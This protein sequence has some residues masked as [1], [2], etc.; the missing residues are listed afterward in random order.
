M[1]NPEL[2]SDLNLEIEKSTPEIKSFLSG[3]Y[4]RDTMDLVIKVNKLSDDQAESVE[5]ETVL[6]ILDLSDHDNISDALHSECDISSEPVMSQVLKDLQEYIF[7][8]IDHKE[9]SIDSVIA[10]DAGEQSQSQSQSQS[11]SKDEDVDVKESRPLRNI[12][13]DVYGKDML[14]PVA[15][16]FYEDKR[17]AV[18]ESQISQDKNISTVQ[19]DTK[20]MKNVSNLGDVMH[21]VYREL[22]AAEDVD[23]TKI[24]QAVN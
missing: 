4:F 5:L 12:I 2:Q 1:L 16:D 21:D 6:N 24:T 15:L 22:P 13:Q 3:K 8:K 7:A 11:K 20:D 17:K 23:V 18:L 14:G 19:Q 10:S 9:A